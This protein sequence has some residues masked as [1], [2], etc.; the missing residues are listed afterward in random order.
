MVHIGSH[1]P[2]HLVQDMIHL[3]GV[4]CCCEKLLNISFNHPFLII[5]W[6]TPSTICHLPSSS[7]NPLIL[8]FW[9][10][11]LALWWKS[12]VLLS[13]ASNQIERENS[14]QNNSSWYCCVLI[15]SFACYID[16]KFAASF[17]AIRSSS[18]CFFSL[19]RDLELPIFRLHATKAIRQVLILERSRNIGLPWGTA[20]LQ[21]SCIAGSHSRCVAHF[22]SNHFGII[23]LLVF[24]ILPWRVRKIGTWSEYDTWRCHT[25]VCRNSSL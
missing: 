24:P 2:L 4:C 14:L 9:R 6:S 13:L 10:R 5:I 17:C 16:S 12:L 1:Y 11:W 3:V 8:F 21:A 23:F 7:I 20:I 25:T 22:S 15:S 18:W 19:I